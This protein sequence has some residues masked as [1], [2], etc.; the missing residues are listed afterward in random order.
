MR[1]SDL[2]SDVCSSDLLRQLPAGVGITHSVG[3]NLA[4]DIG[5]PLRIAG[6][7]DLDRVV[8]MDKAVPAQLPYIAASR[9][10]AEPQPLVNVSTGTGEGLSACIPRRLS[11]KFTHHVTHYAPGLGLSPQPPQLLFDK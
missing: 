2:S 7:T 10:E 11:M 6:L 5:P 9:V 3:I 8:T 4:K 1:I